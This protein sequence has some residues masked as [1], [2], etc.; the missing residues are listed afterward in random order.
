[1]TAPTRLVRPGIRV[2]L[3]PPLLRPENLEQFTV[4]VIDVLRATTSMCVAFGHGLEHLV[5]VA[6]IEACAAY[7][8][9][10]YLVAAERDGLPIAG[11]DFGNSPYSFMRPLQ[12]QRL[13]LTTT[14]G[15][16]ALEAARAARSIVIGAFANFSVLIDH[17]RAQGGPI[18]LLCS[19]WKNAP[20][21]EDSLL[22]GAICHALE[23]QLPL[24]DDAAAIS[25]ALYRHATLRFREFLR[26]S[27]HFQRLIDLGLQKDVKYCLRQNTQPVL[28]VLQN[29]VL[30]NALVKR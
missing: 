19:G 7:R 12:G 4:V 20:N 2:C 28:P 15:T 16:Q 24:A 6:S 25:L 18:L 3:A 13:A 11:F 26:R 10:G 21:L 30:V 5:T 29:G 9:Q 22:A 17:L 27:S 23:P 14:N 8:S 1:M